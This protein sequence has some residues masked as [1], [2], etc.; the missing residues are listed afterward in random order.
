MS[1]QT[2]KLIIEY[3]GTAFSGWQVQNNART[4]QEAIEEA[5]RKITGKNIRIT[6]AG[7]TDAGVHALGQV[8]HFS[9]DGCLPLSAFHHGLNGELPAVIRI[10]HAEETSPEFHARF[11]AVSRTYRYVISRRERAVGH[12]LSW[13]PRFEFEIAPMQRA[14]LCLP[15]KHH[16]ESFCKSGS[17][18]TDC[19]SEVYEASWRE[20]AE[21]VIF[22]ISAIRFFHNMVRILIGTMLEIGSG[23]R[24]AEDLMRIL[25]ARDRSEAGPTVPPHGLYL[26]RIDYKK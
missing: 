24:P 7:R 2:V 19:L 26:V 5:L 14:A 12:C 10:L 16:F 11:D 1:G 13:Y 22:E 3:E 18:E 21:Y 15:G 17:Q 6:G 23:K 4:I 20:T 9:W 8:A 25:N